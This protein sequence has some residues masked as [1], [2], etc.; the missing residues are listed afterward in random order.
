[1]EVKWIKLHS[2]ELC[3]FYS[4]PNVLRVTK[5]RIMRRSCMRA[6]QGPMKW[7]REMAVPRYLSYLVFGGI[8]GQPCLQGYNYGGLIQQVGGWA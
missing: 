5:S 2:K 1:V 6:P 3:G 4:S 8:A 7:V